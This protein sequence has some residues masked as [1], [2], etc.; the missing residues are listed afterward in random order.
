MDLS[1]TF[2]IHQRWFLSAFLLRNLNMP[3]I[4]KA[5]GRR[6]NKKRKREDEENELDPERPTFHY[7]N[8]VENMVGGPQLHGDVT[9]GPPAIQFYGMLDDSEQEY[10]KGADSMLDLNQFANS[11]ERSLFL[12]SVYKEAKGK[13]LRI[14]NS[15]SCSRL[16]ERLICV[17][18]PSQLK[19][20]FQKLIGQ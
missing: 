7:V 9:E 4:H 6:A 11:E 16:L 17:S 3:Q 5:R 2:T 13:E 1:E 19:T 14:A 18:T 10:F 12:A 8:D 15:Q 20:L